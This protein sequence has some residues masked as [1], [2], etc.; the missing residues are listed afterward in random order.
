MPFVQMENISH[1][2]Q[3]CQQPPL[4]LQQHDMFL[5]VDLYESKDPTQVLQCL[6]AFSRAASSANPS[7]FPTAIG[8]R[9]GPRRPPQPAE[10]RRRSRGRRHQPRGRGISN[11]S[12]GSSVTNN[13]NSNSIGGSR[14]PPDGKQDGRFRLGP[15]EPDQE[16]HLG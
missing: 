4:N 1:F 14:P 6:G 8:S 7:T 11:A 10:H 3:A 13:N 12:N 9:G 2:L 16:P 5:T 15:L